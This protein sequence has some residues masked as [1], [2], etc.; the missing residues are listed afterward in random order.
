MG[1]TVESGGVVRFVD[2]PRPGSDPC[3]QGCVAPAA[4]GTGFANATPPRA[5]SDATTHAKGIS[6]IYKRSFVNLRRAYTRRSGC[7]VVRVQS[8]LAMGPC[9][10]RHGVS[11]GNL[12]VH[13][14][15]VIRRSDAETDAEVPILTCGEFI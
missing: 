8:L 13:F 9:K 6:F 15:S 7:G 14:D 2:G 5:S 12:C 1:L 3:K 10:Q 4:G 11:L